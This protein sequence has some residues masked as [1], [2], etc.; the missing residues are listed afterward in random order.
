[1]VGGLGNDSLT[2]GAGSDTFVFAGSDF[3][4]DM[5][6][7]MKVGAGSEDVVEFRGGLFENFAAV[8]AAAAQS[9]NHVVITVDAINSIT[10]QNVVLA[11]LHADDFRFA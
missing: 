5:I 11:N 9:G 10:F 2:G 1:M 6:S 8:R 3:G 4:R 7:D